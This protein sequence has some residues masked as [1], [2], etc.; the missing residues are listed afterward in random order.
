MNIASRTLCSC[1]VYATNGLPT[2]TIVSLISWM[3]VMVRRTENWAKS[4]VKGEPEGYKQKKKEKEKNPR[5]SGKR[6]CKL[7]EQRRDDTEGNLY[8]K[9]GSARPVT[10]R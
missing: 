4:K 6:G 8:A 7:K 5:M 3:P 1:R 10:D 2:E 9:H